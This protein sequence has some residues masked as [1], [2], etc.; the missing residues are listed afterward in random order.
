MSHPFFFRA[1]VLARAQEVTNPDDPPVVA[2]A[3]DTDGE[4]YDYIWGWETG[5][6]MALSDGYTVVA[7]S[8]DGSMTV[9][10]AQAL[11][12]SEQALYAD[13]FGE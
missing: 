11:Y 3:F 7:T 6:S 10:R 4:V 5:Q 8:D 12:D 1:S 2:V 9:E 13:C